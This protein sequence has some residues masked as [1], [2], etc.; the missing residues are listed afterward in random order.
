MVREA[1]VIRQRFGRCLMLW[2]R[3]RSTSGSGQS[4]GEPDCLSGRAPP[5][6]PS[7][8]VSDPART[9]ATPQEEGDRP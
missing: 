7:H 5:P 1:A 4:P 8:E 3:Y 2:S 6:V 9:L